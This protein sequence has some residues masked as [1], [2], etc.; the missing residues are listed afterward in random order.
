MTFSIRL[1]LP[2][3]RKSRQWWTYMLPLGLIHKLRHAWQGVGGGGFRE[4]IGV[5][6][7]GRGFVNRPSTKR[8]V[9]LI[10]CLYN[11]NRV[12][13]IVEKNDMRLRITYIFDF[14][15][16]K[17]PAIYLDLTKRVVGRVVKRSHVDSINIESPFKTHLLLELY[18]FW[19]LTTLPLR[20][21]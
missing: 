19:I 16:Q 4:K 20:K 21:F 14:A 11:V 12:D 15:M 2:C 13:Y 7:E 8:N 6:P 17:M 3:T 1:A 9:T 10:W 5:T 18:S